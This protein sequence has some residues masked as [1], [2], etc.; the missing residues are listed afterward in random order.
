MSSGPG[1]RSRLDPGETDEDQE[2]C[3][4]CSCS[5][6]RRSGWELLPAA[7]A[8]GPTETLAVSS[9][10][11]RTAGTM[12]IPVGAPGLVDEH[13]RR[14][15]DRVWAARY[16][17]ETGA[18]L[19]FGSLSRRHVAGGSARGPRRTGGAGLTGTRRGTRAAARTSCARRQA[20]VPRPGDAIAGVRPARAHAR[21]ATDVRGGGRSRACPRRRAWPPWSHLLD[22]AR[23]RDA[24]GRPPRARPRRGRSTP[25]SAGATWLGPRPDGP[26][27]PRADAPGDGRGQRGIRTS[28][29][30]PCPARTIRRSSRREWCRTPSGSASTSRRSSRW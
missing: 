1:G 5:A 8:T 4:R 3:S 7:G 18:A 2:A 20:A 23:R 29:A 27:V 11:F 28:S 6:E 9:R 17:V 16:G 12:P 25:G 30:L 13:A 15:A 26:G 14:H 19:R 22:E 10:R 21:A 24:E